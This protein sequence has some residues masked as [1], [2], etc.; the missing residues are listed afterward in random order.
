M[1]SVGVD[2]VNY[3]EGWEEWLAITMAD[4]RLIR[5]GVRSVA[6]GDDNRVG[7]EV[8]EVVCTQDSPI[9]SWTALGCGDG[10]GG[11]KWFAG[12]TMVRMFSF[13]TCVVL[14]LTKSVL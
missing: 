4:R 13:A 7:D 2:R 6:V 10:E 11:S 8:T 3:A 9:L 1:L 5:T 12:T 14:G